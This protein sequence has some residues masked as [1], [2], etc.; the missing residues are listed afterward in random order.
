MTASPAPW[1]LS[2]ATPPLSL[3]DYVWAKSSPLKG[4]PGEL[5][6]EHSR[7][8][9]EFAFRIR[10]RIGAIPGMP[11]K[12]WL[13]VLLSA[14]CHDC[15]KTCGG[16]QCQ[17]G[18]S[19]RPAIRWGERHE[20]YS[21]AFL[22]TLLQDLD[23]EDLLWVATGVATHHRP[24]DSQERGTRAILTLYPEPHAEDFTRRFDPVDPDTAQALLDWL[25]ATSASYRLIPR[26]LPTGDTRRTT[27]ELGAAAHHLL[28]Q[29]RARWM[30]RLPRSRRDDGLA[31]VLLLGAVTAA[32][33]LASAPRA[34][35]LK[36]LPI[37][38]Y[39]QQLTQRRSNENQQVRPYQLQAAAVSGHLILLAPTGY[40]KTDAVLL[41]GETATTEIARRCGG[42]PRLI[43]A[44]PYLASINAMTLRLVEDLH[45]PDVGVLHS[46][47][48]LYHL[49][50]LREDNTGIDEDTAEVAAAEHA[51]KAVEASRQHRE[52]VRVT[53]PYQLLRG[54][55]GGT[56]HASTLLDTA[57]NSVL[58]F[59]ELHAYE[60]RRL[61]MILAMMSLT[62]RLGSRVA[63]LSATLPT[64]LI[65]LIQRAL[66]PPGSPEPAPVVL[67]AYPQQDWPARHR[68]SL[69]EKHLTDP[70]TQQAIAADLAQGKSVLVVANNIADAHYLYGVLEPQCTQQHGAGSALL[71]HSR[72]RGM[73][74]SALEAGIHKRFGANTATPQPGLLIGTQAL[75]V[76]L[77]CSLDVLYTSCATLEALLQRVRPRQPTR[78]AHRRPGAHLRPRVPN[79]HRRARPLRRRRLPRGTDP[80]DLGVAHP[81]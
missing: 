2:T 43:Y 27:A 78:P 69:H 74:R 73:D 44:L 65:T 14:L 61:G 80:R 25:I 59:D 64:R 22:P 37:L 50:R 45:T 54:A 34:E 42:R 63:V 77:N 47:A 32:D 23:D 41:W 66:T 38:G 17:I 24:L 3:L 62:A 35:L 1:L 30:D 53:T 9:L 13:W 68:I 11:P 16:F 8:T 55:L 76:S 19:S 58:I 56:R 10:D 72:F 15:G 36:T 39:R 51:V 71:L 46:R 29:L 67:D 52:L 26:L 18:N 7:T 81:P 4:Q 31:A 5:L 28:Q 79:P 33:H 57:T 40:G 21:L 6:T 49:N 20:V 75:E 48:G 70:Q 60:P 12:F